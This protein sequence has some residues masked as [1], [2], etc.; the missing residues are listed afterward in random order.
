MWRVVA[1][2]VDGKRQVVLIE[3]DP[4]AEQP[5]ARDGRQVGGR[6]GERHQPAIQVDGVRCWRSVDPEDAIGLD[7]IGVPDV[8]NA[9]N[10]RNLAKLERCLYA[11]A[12]CE[13]FVDGLEVQLVN[14]LERAQPAQAGQVHL[15]DADVASLVDVVER[16]GEGVPSL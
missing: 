3:A 16:H 8:G 1:A 12:F 7:D 10:G 9:I 13:Y 4:Q 5:R 11:V 6:N 15:L 14:E 2:A